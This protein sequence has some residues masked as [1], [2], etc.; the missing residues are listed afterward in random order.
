MPDKEIGQLIPKH[1]DRIAIRHFCEKYKRN[2]RKQSLLEKLRGKLVGKEKEKLQQKQK[3]TRK[4]TRFIEIG[5]LCASEKNGSYRHV[6][7]KFGGGT[8]RIAMPKNSTCFDILNK[9]KDLFFPENKS[10]KGRLEEF[11]IELLDYKCNPFTNM[12]LTIQDIYEMSSL[13]NVR[14]YFA[15]VPKEE[16]NVYDNEEYYIPCT[17]T[18]NDTESKEPSSSELATEILNEIP[19]IN[20][21][22]D[23]DSSAL[24]SIIL[25]SC[26]YM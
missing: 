26:R 9:A 2:V 15:T 6:R 11:N 23:F 17:V 4:S 13:T 3:K 7:T 16:S 25:H 20:D 10:T 14:F 1:G 19:A 5:W 21:I 8:R 22:E 18:S 24:V 12:D